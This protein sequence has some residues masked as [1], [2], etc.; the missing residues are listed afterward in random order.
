MEN[1]ASLKLSL[2]PAS[3]CFDYKNNIFEQED[4]SPT[5]SCESP[6]SYTSE[7]LSYERS[8]LNS[9]CSLSPTTNCESPQNGT[10]NGGFSEC[11]ETRI[12]RENVDMRP[13]NSSRIKRRGLRRLR[14][15]CKQTLE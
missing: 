14:A 10:F 1:S 3:G 6:A 9:S 13:I 7:D 4:T 15:I 5:Q 8:P 2:I 11:M 12:L